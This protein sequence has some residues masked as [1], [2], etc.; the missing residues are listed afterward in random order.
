MP[1]NSAVWLTEKRAAFEVGPAPYTLPGEHEILIKN[2]A[3]AINPV[4]WLAPLIGDF[5]FPWVEYPFILGTDVAGEVVEVGPGV[6]RFKVGDRV[7]GLAVG[8]DKERK[9]SAEGAFQEYTILVDRMASPIPDAMSFEAACVL[10]LGLSTAACGLFEKGHLALDHPTDDPTP[11]G[12]TVIIWGGASSVGSNAI[13]LAVAAG[14]DVI[15]TT[16]PKNFDYAKALGAR[17]VFDYRSSTVVGDIIRAMNG[18]TSAGAL[19]IGIGSTGPCLDIVRACPGTKVVSMASTPISFQGA[20]P[21]PRKLSW[22]A[23]TLARMLLAN[24]ALSIKALISGVRTPFIFGSALLHNE[25]G[26]MIYIDFL[27]AALASGRFVAAP[28]PLVVGHGVAAI[29]LGLETQKKGVS[30]KKVVVSL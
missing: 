22:L 11:K 3:V 16:S 9:T 8:S 18:R 25:V 26:P 6:T 17:E 20:P 19:A 24:A 14:Y 12:K 21:G 4:D 28:D 10:P 29:L 23:P 15:S 13:Q 30:A 2:R 1:S 5:V 27:P 7:L